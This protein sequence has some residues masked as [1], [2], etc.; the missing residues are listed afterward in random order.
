MTG[1]RFGRAGR[2]RFFIGLGALVITVVFIKLQLDE[3]RRIEVQC[4]QQK[5]DLEKKSKSERNEC[6]QLKYNLE[7][8]S[9]KQ[10]EIKERTVQESNT[11][12]TSLQQHY[13]LLKNQ[14]EDLKEECSKTKTSQ[15]DKI[16]TLQNSL[17]SYKKQ[18]SCEEK[19]NEIEIWKAK[20]YAL[21]NEKT[22]T[23]QLD[24]RSTTDDTKDIA[25]LKNKIESPST[26][27]TV[28]KNFNAQIAISDKLYAISIKYNNNNNTSTKSI[29]KDKENLVKAKTPSTASIV[30]SINQIKFN[31]KTE[32]NNENGTS[33]TIENNNNN[34]KSDQIE[35]K[36]I[37]F[38]QGVVPFV[39][40]NLNNLIDQQS[41]ENRNQRENQK[42][43]DTLKRLQK[44]NGEDVGA[45]EETDNSNYFVAEERKEENL[46][47]AYETNDKSKKGKGK[48]DQ[49]NIN[50]DDLQVIQQASDVLED[51]RNKLK[52]EVNEDQGKA[53]ADEMN[54]QVE[55]EDDDEYVDHR[56]HQQGQ[57]VRERR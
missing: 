57:A 41:S 51:N 16:N 19:D 49:S 52:N 43:L 14:C 23:K 30:S 32:V 27:A 24:F 45:R 40:P 21:L 26:H 31:R 22:A 18:K 15:L 8:Q 54:F 2:S 13:K 48:K 6:E 53:Y 35:Q 46:N 28:T 34:N 39:Q 33:I 7:I 44:E 42:S 29:E 56:G 11:K 1:T 10:G 25:V 37:K 50:D 9:Q 55:D 38:P 5:E 20:Y 3:T 12:L 4:E 17:N 47:Q 36:L